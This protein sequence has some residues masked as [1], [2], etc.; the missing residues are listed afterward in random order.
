MLTAF[1]LRL[2][3]LVVYYW[4]SYE[5]TY[6]RLIHN[7]LRPIRAYPEIYRSSILL[8]PY[9]TVSHPPPSSCTHSPWAQEGTEQGFVWPLSVILI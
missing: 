4:I 5:A 8:V 2:K 6:K 3:M 7:L 1:P 9:P